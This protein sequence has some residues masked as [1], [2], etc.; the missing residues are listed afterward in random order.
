M[1]DITM[2]DGENC[3]LAKECFRHTAEPDAFR[4][5][6][7]SVSPNSGPR[8][9]AE[10]LPQY[11]SVK[12]YLAAVKDYLATAADETTQHKGASTDGIRL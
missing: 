6:W 11:S 8:D 4:Q 12:D 3:K 5:S 1:A 7:F 2:C 9:C 10:F